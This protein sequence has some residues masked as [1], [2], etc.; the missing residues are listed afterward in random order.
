MEDERI[1]IQA[2]PSRRAAEVCTLVPED[3]SDNPD[4][5]PLRLKVIKPPSGWQLIDVGELWRHRELLFFFAWRDVKVR[6][7]Q[8]LLGAGWAVVQPLLMM[9]VFTIFLGRVAGAGSTDLPY[10]LFVYTGLLPWMFF[11]SAIASAGNSVVS[12]ESIITKIYFPRLLVP[13]AA[14]AAT[15]VDCCCALG[16]LL[17]MLLYYRVWPGATLLLVPV[18]IALTGLLALGIGTLLAAMNVAYRDVKYVIPF[19][20]QLWMFATPAIYMQVSSAAGLDQ[21]RP[22]SAAVAGLETAAADADVARPAGHDRYASVSMPLF[23]LNPMNGFVAFFRA[24]VLGTPLPWAQLAAGTAITAVALGVG[25]F[26]FRR[27][28]NTFADVI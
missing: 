17:L 22:E 26:Y 16:M 20:I 11:S 4:V 1:V 24:A 25:V 9:V 15:V 23:R 5:R 28:E 14:V 12:S 6:Y 19:M 18:L 13:F 10:P 7:R 27:V 21:L 3:E 2:I 8:T